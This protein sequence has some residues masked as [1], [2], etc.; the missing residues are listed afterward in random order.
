MDKIDE[1]IKFLKQIPYTERKT[2]D[3]CPYMDFEYDVVWE[4]DE[5]IIRPEDE[6]NYF[7]LDIDMEHFEG[8]EVYDEEGKSDIERTEITA[9]N[10]VEYWDE[11]S[12]LIKIEEATTEQLN[13]IYSELPCNY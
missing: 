9:V 1:L 12:N 8:G 11:D 7:T 10:K 13:I 3:S 4:K 2:I 6:T 5:L